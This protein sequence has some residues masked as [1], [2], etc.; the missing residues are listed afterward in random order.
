MAEAEETKGPV[1]KA[2][3][4]ISQLKEMEHYSRSN[5]EKLTAMCLQ[6]EDELKMKKASDVVAKLLNA[7]HAFEDQAKAVVEA[8]EAECERL[9]K[10]K[11]G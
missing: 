2:R 1:D 11:A 5:I 4:L 9:D 6:L 3:D 8:L 7:Q 10:K